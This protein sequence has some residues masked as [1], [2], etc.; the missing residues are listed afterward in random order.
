MPTPPSTPR[1][2]RAASDPERVVDMHVHIVGNGSAGTGCWVRVLPS[3]WPLYAVMLQHIGLPVSVLKGD[4]DRLYAARLAQLARESSL[5]AVVILAQEQVYDEN[6]R[7]LIG[8]GSAFVPNDYVLRLAG[9]N[10]EFLPAV[11]IHP[12][13]PDALDE[14]DRCLAGGAVMLKILPNCHNIDCNL[15]R[16][17][18]FWERM[19]EAGLPLLAHTGGEHTM[20]V[21]RP[22]LADPRTLRLP[23]ECGVNVIA[24]HCATKSGLFD[25]QYFDVLPEMFAKHPNLYADISAFNVPIRGSVV[26]R[27]LAEPALSRMVHGSDYPVPVFGHWAWMQGFVSWR[28]FRAWEG[29]PNI[30]E[31]DYQL[32][33]AM[34][35][36]PEVFTRINKLLRKVPAK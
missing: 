14:L 17:R 9:E 29:E 7:L 13:R 23:L 24:A 1:P 27:C 2:K 20:Q 21:V 26:P 33:R 35:F 16:Y 31:K 36:P 30:L 10:P 4:L 12:A 3:K 6:G 15:P 22:D 5:D 19:A 28:D 34:G 25:P 11:S 18:R 8:T 32:K